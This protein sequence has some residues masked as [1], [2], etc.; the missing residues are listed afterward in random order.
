MTQARART[1]TVTRR[2]AI[3]WRLWGGVSPRGLGNGGCGGRRWIGKNSGEVRRGSGRWR[4]Y[5][6]D[7]DD[8]AKALVWSAC[9]DDVRVDDEVRSEMR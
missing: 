9:L 5:D 1:R 3:G 6:E 7:R 8:E 4:D 2:A